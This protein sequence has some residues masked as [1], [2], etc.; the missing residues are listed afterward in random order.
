MEIYYIN[1]KLQKRCNN[2]KAAIKEWGPIIASRL[3]Q[4]LM[5]LNAFDNLAM[6]SHLPPLRLH[7]LVGKRKDQFGVD[8]VKN[9]FR[10]VFKAANEPVPLLND[11]GIDKEKVTEIMI[12]EVTNYHVE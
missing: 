10:I 9:S 2:E 8:I 4:R 12:L 3:T 11:G 5:E 6:V 1:N 7:Q